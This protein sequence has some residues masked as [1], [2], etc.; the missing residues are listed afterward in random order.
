MD[1]L[2]ADGSALLYS[3]ALG[4]IGRAI[5]LDSSGDAFVTGAGVFVSKFNPTG[6]QLF[7]KTLSN[8]STDSG[9][10]IA[11]DSSRKHRDR[12]R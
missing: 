6:A 7:S 5:V 3:T 8:A 10:A 9:Q 4:M 12:G 1:K 11:L 2:S